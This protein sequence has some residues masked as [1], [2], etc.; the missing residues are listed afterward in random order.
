VAWSFIAVTIGF[1]MSTPT[2]EAKTT[3]LPSLKQMPLKSTFLLPVWVNISASRGSGGFPGVMSTWT[4]LLPRKTPNF[5]GVGPTL[6]SAD[7][8]S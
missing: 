3:M 8:S 1:I 5:M 4:P 7:L 2:L 6:P